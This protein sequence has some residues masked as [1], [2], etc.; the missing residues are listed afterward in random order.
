MNI[1]Y[2]ALAGFCFMLGLAALAGIS[3]YMGAWLAA[4]MGAPSA[5]AAITT[6]M[7]LGFAG[8]VCGAI[9]AVLDSLC[10]HWFGLW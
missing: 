4:I 7:L 5:S 2:G 6:V 3:I 8:A 9:I 10:D 1:L